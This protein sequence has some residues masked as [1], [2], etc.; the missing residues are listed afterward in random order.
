M[1]LSFGGAPVQRIIQQDY[2][3]KAWMDALFPELLYRADATPELWEGKRGEEKLWSRTGLLDPVTEPLVPGNDPNPDQYGI[4]QWRAIADQ[5]GN[6]VD[7]HMPTSHVALA[8]M[9]LRDVHTLGLNAGQSLNRLARNPLYRAYNAGNTVATVIAAIGAVQIHV[10]SL[11][12]FT[13]ALDNGRPVPVSAVNTVT[14]TFPGIAEPDNFV[15]AAAPDIAAEP[16]GPGWLTLQ[17]AL[18]VGLAAR[19]AVV[20]EDATVIHRVGGG[21][22]VDAIAAADILTLQ[23]I[24]DAVAILEG[25]DVKAHPDGYYHHHMSTTAK[26][27]VFA[28]NQFQRLHEGLPDSASYRQFIVGVALSCIHYKNT[29]APD[30]TN[31]GVLRATGA[32]AQVSPQLG[33][34]VVN[35][36]GVR[37][38]RTIIT[39]RGSLAEC[40]MDESAYISEV[41]VT[42][43]I[44]QFNVINDGVAVMTDRIR[45]TVRRPLDKLQQIVA[46][47]WSWTGDFP[48]P[49]DALVGNDARYKRAVIIEH[50]L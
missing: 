17:N 18:T 32:T 2:L 16:F 7:T 30:N 42:G 26:A 14:V 3:I 10:A 34:E 15:I 48:V 6:N 25:N 21:N 1:A 37:I 24:I 38:G 40:Y 35:E 20:A 29:E 43:K 19:Q 11:N 4:E 28:D 9:L 44:G 50:A 49:T 46:N 5:Y 13:E 22:S 31:T 27:Q 41:G 23:D 45:L 33:A 47:T 12:G 8:N 36:T 39:G